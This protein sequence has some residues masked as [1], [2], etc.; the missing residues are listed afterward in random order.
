MQCQ[1]CKD[2]EATIHLTEINDGVRTEMHICQNCALKEGITIKSQ[3]P[4]NELLSNLLAVQPS[5]EEIFG[6]DEKGK[7]CPYCGITFEQFR[8]QAVLGCPYDYEFFEKSLSP[9]IKNAHH[10]H[11]IHCGKIPSKVSTDD[12]KEIELLNLKHQLEA[13]VAK[14]NYELAAQLRDKIS[15]MQS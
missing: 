12:K 14:E 7:V 10:G 6:S 8:K 5:D 9:L 11:G 1:I 13:A 2:N 4:L 3:I 15:Q